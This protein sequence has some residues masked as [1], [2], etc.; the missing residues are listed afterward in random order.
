VLITRETHF[1][2]LAKRVAPVASN[3]LIDWGMKRMQW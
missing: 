1:M 3:R 2:D